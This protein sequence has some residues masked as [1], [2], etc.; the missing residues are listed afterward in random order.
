MAGMQKDLILDAANAVDTETVEK[1]ENGKSTEASRPLC[2]RAELNVKMKAEYIYDMLLYHMY[3]TFGGFMLNVAGLAVII[4]G[5]MRYSFH[6]SSLAGAIGLI[7]FGVILLAVTP[8]N[9]KLRAKNTTKLPKYQHIIH[10]GID[11]DGIDESINGHSNHYDWNQILKAV[12]TPKTITFY[13]SD[14]GSVLVFPK[15]AFDP[16]TF[17]SAMWH[18]SHNVVMGRIFIR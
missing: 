10:Y 13:L 3:S 18:L 7:L 6:K 17:Q 15:E 12:S 16:K 2:P 1:I 9:L 11:N 4:T 5:G 8:L 14:G